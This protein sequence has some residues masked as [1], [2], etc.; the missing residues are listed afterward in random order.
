MTVS[1]L[2]KALDVGRP[3]VYRLV[4]TLA[5]HDLV[6]RF[7]DG[8]VR[9]SVGLLALAA[10]AQST[11]RQVA[12]PILRDLANEVGATAH[13]TLAD[14]DEAFAVAVE[15]PT[16]TDFHVSYRV[17]SVHPVSVGAAGKAILA[18]RAGNRGL[19]ESLGE[20]QAGAH[21]Y[22]LPLVG[23]AGLEGSVGVVALSPL[24]G[25]GRCE[26]RWSPP[27]GGSWRRSTPSERQAAATM[28][29]GHLAEAD[30]RTVAAARAPD[31]RHG[32]AVLEER[33]LAAV[34]EA[35]RLGAVP[36]ALEQAAEGVRLRSAHGARCEQVADAQRCAVDGHVR[37]H[38]GRAT[39]TC[40]CSCGCETT[41]P[42]TRTVSSRSSPK[43]RRLVPGEVVEH[44]QETGR[45]V[46]TRASS[47]AANGVTQAEIDV[48]KDLPRNGPSGT[49]SQAWMS[50]ALQSLSSTT[51]K[52]WSLRV[53][54]RDTDVPSWLGWPT[55][56]PTSHSMSSSQARSEAGD[57]V[58][59]G[60]RCPLGRTTSVP[61]TTTVPARPW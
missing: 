56:K 61:L 50:R 5:Q 55:T 45:A 39:S 1:Q 11:V 35:D 17:G 44:V 15:E 18:G 41:W 42:L 20:L 48:A 53:A 57:S 34:G 46:D 30:R 13:L 52:M 4:A 10:G 60:R 28:R 33:E 14:G 7:A 24:D 27:R 6:R 23:V 59:A 51:P 36:G 29:A 37:Q 12:Q 25:D 8:Q 16:W 43:T 22:A 58:G 3:V 21:G 40:P 31:D 26:P 19:V 32:V 49:Y 9:L 38:L 54:D 2:A 47:R